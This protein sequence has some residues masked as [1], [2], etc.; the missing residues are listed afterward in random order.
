M[1]VSYHIH[2]SIIVQLI[3]IVHINTQSQ[4]ELWIYH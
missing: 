1:I 2:G 3:E 4:F